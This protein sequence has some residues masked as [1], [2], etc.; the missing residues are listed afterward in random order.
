M[1]RIYIIRHCKAEGQ[2]ENAKLT[3]EGLTQ[4]LMLR[5]Y[6]EHV[7]IDQIISS[8]YIRAVQSIE[9]LGEFKGIEIIKDTRLSERILSTENYTDWLDKLNMTFQDK[10]LTF[11]GGESSN[12][13]LF[14]ISSVFE[15]VINSPAENVILVTHGAI[16]SLLLNSMDDHFGFDQW[17]TLTNPD[18][19]LIEVQEGKKTFKRIWNSK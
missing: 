13:A 19:Y 2:E 1:K 16:M 7:K 8:H 17:Q 6:F 3:S 11:I 12:E 9:P 14:R 5:D 4:A 15:E 18:I 10:S